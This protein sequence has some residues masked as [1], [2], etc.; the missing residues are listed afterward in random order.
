MRKCSKDK[1]PDKRNDET[2]KDAHM[3]CTCFSSQI[4]TSMQLFFMSLG[5]GIVSVK[6]ILYVHIDL[7][8]VRILKAL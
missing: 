1:V 6:G 8:H 3:P 4:A 5:G 7:E 2:P